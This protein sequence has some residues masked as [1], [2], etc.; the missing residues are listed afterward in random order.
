[1]KIIGTK[2]YQ[3]IK[4]EISY[5]R[6]EISQLRQ[7]IYDIRNSTNERFKVHEMNVNGV[8]ATVRTQ[9]SDMNKDIR[10]I[11]EDAIAKSLFI[12]DL[13]MS[14]EEKYGESYH[15]Y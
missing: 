6:R 15:G 2:E 12:Q 8:K 5:L 7:S 1:M 4:A 10:C 14:V 9:L 13:D 3:E 11:Q